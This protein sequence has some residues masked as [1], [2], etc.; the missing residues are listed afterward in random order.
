MAK[1]AKA[2]RDAAIA[3]LRDILPRGATVYTIV[4]HVSRS[5]MA[6]DIAAI[7]GLPG[8]GLENISGYVAD[9][10]GWRWMD[11]GAVRVAGCGMDMG[12]HLVYVLAQTLFRDDPD[13]TPEE[14]ATCPRYCSVDVHLERH[15]Y[16]LKHRWV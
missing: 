6:R 16:A 14:E 5:G 12:F 4:K 2:E 8:G 15:G 10:I 9:A 3:H 7:A 1:V 11:N 13:P